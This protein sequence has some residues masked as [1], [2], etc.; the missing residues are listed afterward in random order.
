MSTEI[1]DRAENLGKM[2]L[3]GDSLISEFAKLTKEEEENFD[4]AKSL[5]AKFLN[6]DFNSLAYEENDQ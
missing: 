1:V 6:I 4:V 5:V 2:I 3:E